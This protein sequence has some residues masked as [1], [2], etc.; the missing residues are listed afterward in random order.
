[1]LIMGSKCTNAN[2][3]VVWRCQDTSLDM[4]D[5]I[6]PRGSTTLQVETL[7]AWITRCH[8]M[9]RLSGLGDSTPVLVRTRSPSKVVRA[10]NREHYQQEKIVYIFATHVA[11]NSSLGVR[12]PIPPT[13]LDA[14]E[15]FF[16]LGD[17]TS[18]TGSFDFSVRA[19]IRSSQ[20]RTTSS[21]CRVSKS[22]L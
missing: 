2:M 13:G 11:L 15:G 3:P 14:V 18:S 22:M 9:T 6:G 21:T 20:T 16:D 10:M 5:A 17:G 4:R 7:L 8:H 1:M 12:G 19:D